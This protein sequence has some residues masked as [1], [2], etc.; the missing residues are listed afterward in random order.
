MPLKTPKALLF[1]PMGS[2]HRRFNASNMEA[3]KNLGCE[4]HLLANFERGDGTE[5]QNPEYAESCRQKG[6]TVHSLPF[7]RASLKSNLNLVPQIRSLLQRE[8]YDLIHAHTET[9]GLLLRLSMGAA[10]GARFIYTPHGMSFYKGSSWKS[11]LLYRPIERWICKAMDANLAMNGEEY[12]VLRQWNSRTACFVHGIGL[13]MERTQTVTATRSTVRSELGIPHGARM[14]V[15]VGEL[16]DN[17]NHAVVIRALGE[18]KCDDLFY[19]I[20][21]VGPRHNELLRHAEEA[22]L[23]DKVILAGYRRDIPDV[24]HASELFIFPSFHEGL[25]VALM[26]SMAAG[27]PIICSRIRGN[28]DLIQDGVNGYLFAPESASELKSRISQMLSDEKTMKKMGVQNECDAHAY[29]Y[30]IVVRELEAVYK[31]N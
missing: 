12:E 2:V 4:V 6:V 7:V 9:G 23:R 17:K 13:D 11:Q 31:N 16:D 24:L 26:E 29:S 14:I 1:A 15:S 19:V 22:G 25:P 8:G 10:K 30:H 28:V 27:L 5:Q 20:C 21:G 3:L 18:L